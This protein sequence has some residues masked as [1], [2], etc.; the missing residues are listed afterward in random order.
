LNE[1]S[2]QKEEKAEINY[3]IPV[4]AQHKGETFS[5]ELLNSK[6]MIRF[7]GKEYA[8]PTTAAKVIVIDWKEVNGWDFWRYLNPSS[9]NWEKIGKLR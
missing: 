8:T 7:D 9:G 5:A 3:P 1:L 4:K 2:G 6:G